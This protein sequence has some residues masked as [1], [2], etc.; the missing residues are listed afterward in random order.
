LE[1]LS[2]DDLL[3]IFGQ[4]IKDARQAA[5]LTQEELAEQAGVTTRT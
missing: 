5:V 3:N 4:K 1:E 2:V